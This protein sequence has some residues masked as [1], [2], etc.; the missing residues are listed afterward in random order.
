MSVLTLSCPCGMKLKA[1][2]AVPGRVGKCPRCGSLLKVPDEPEAPAPVAPVPTRGASFVGVRAPRISTAR[3]LRQQSDGL[4]MPPRQAETRLA[5]SLT[6]PLWNASGL[7]LLAFMPPLLVFATMPLFMILPM[8]RSGLAVAMVGVIW[9]IPQLLILLVVLGYVLLFLA[10]VLTTSA[11]GEVMVPRSPGWD[12]S[13]IGR[14]LTRWFWALMIG[15]VI[16]GMPP[17]LYWIWCG[18]VDW[19]DRVVLVDLILPGM[20][21]A[22]MALLSA[23]IHDSP[24]AA[25]PVTVIAAI[26]RVGWGYVI[27]CVF[28]GSCL[29]VLGSAFAAIL[30]IRDGLAQ[31]VAYYAF[32]VALLYLGMVMLRRLGLFCYR[33]AVVLE[34]FPDRASRA[35]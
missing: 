4:I 23:L 33:H 15:G 12:L 6:Y 25:N 29:L 13:E 9:S 1:P 8:V 14:G 34:W 10:K 24:L 16:G 22:Q 5:D 27:P 26:L 28:T 21:Y 3:D 7:G 17:L 18:D 31:L 2:G 30:A 35:E 20:A 32:W 19:L 11:C